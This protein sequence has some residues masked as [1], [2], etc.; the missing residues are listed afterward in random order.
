[1]PQKRTS[2]KVTKQESEAAQELQAP[3]RDSDNGK[4]KNLFKSA[5]S[6]Q[7][8]G[9]KIDDGENLTYFH[10]DDFFGDE[11]ADTSSSFI[12]TNAIKMKGRFGWLVRFTVEEENGERCYV[13]QSLGDDESNP[14][15]ERMKYVNYFR[16][17]TQPIGPVMFVKLQGNFNNPYYTIQDAVPF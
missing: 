15:E 3:Q 1:M 12:I 7:Q 4:P 9:I 10:P 8:A 5:K 2:T 13:S 6:L 16:T 14:N 11:D 17:N